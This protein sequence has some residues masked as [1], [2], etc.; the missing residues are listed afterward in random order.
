MSLCKLL[1]EFNFHWSAQASIYIAK[2]DKL[3]KLAAD[4]GCDSLFIGFESINQASLMNAHKFANKVDEY[5]M[6]IKKIHDY[7]MGI[8]GA[9][10]F[11]FDSDKKDV[12]RGTV[13]FCNENEIEMAQFTVLTP[14]PGT[15]LFN[16]LNKENRIFTFNWAYYDV[17]HPVFSPKFMK[18]YE[19]FD[20][21]LNC[22]NE[23]YTGLKCWR[24]ILRRRG[25]S[26]SF[27]FNFDFAKM[28]TLFKLIRV[29]IDR[30]GF[31]KD[32][33]TNNK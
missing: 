11:G 27:W 6:L 14:L 25:G 9:F 3:L 24:R 5:K 10:V 13:D 19:L 22:Y 17:L 31:Y 8:E 2:N 32:L 30:Y 15:E 20:G 16:K 18:A 4:S 29:G 12:F 26:W 23:F 1:S 28:I 7:G 21:L 33:R